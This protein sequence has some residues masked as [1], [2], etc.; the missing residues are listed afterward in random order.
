M[1]LNCLW[2]IYIYIYIMYILYTYVVVP[3]PPSVRWEMRW[4]SHIFTLEQP[5]SLRWNSQQLNS[6]P[7]LSQKKCAGTAITKKRTTTFWVF[8]R[9]IKRYSIRG[10]STSSAVCSSCGNS[11]TRVSF[12]DIENSHLSL[13]SQRIPYNDLQ[14]PHPNRTRMTQTTSST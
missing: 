8:Q 10:T 1:L 7:H 6:H 12:S 14:C 9:G 13:R 11:A 3:P 4:N 5:E 2:Y